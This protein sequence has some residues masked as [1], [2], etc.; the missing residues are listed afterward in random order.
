MEGA[1]TRGLDF[2]V[3]AD[4]PTIV[5]ILKLDDRSSH[6]TFGLFVDVKLPGCVEL[7]PT[8]ALKVVE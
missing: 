1:I 4:P 6:S 7:R 2:D 5:V 3:E 8:S